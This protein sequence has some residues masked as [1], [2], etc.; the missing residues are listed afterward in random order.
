M[1]NIVIL[2]FMEPLQKTADEP[3]QS[4]HHF[5]LISLKAEKDVRYHA[6]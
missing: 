3:L 4:D 6:D 1:W 5:H 2:Y